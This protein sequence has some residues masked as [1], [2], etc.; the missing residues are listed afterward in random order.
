M[1]SV[2]FIFSIAFVLPNVSFFWYTKRTMF[3]LFTSKSDSARF[4]AFTLFNSETMEQ[5]TFE[6]L[7]K[8]D[9]RVYSCGPT[10]YDYAHIGNL[11]AYIFSDTLKRAL[12]YNGYNVNHT[13][14]YTDFGHLTSDADTG[15]DKMMKG[16]RRENMEVSLE[17]MRFLS[18]KYIEAFSTDI[19]SLNIL[20]PTQFARASDYVTEQIALIKTLEEKGY[21]YTTSDGVY[22]DISKFPSYGRL[23]NINVQE[24]KSGARVEKNSEKKNPAD[25]AVWKNG[26]L[27]WDSTWGK[28]FP[29]WHIECSAMAFATLGKQIDI[30]TGGVDNMPTHH[31]GEIAQCE[32]ATGKQFSKYWMHSEHI[33]INETKIG[34]SEGNGIILQ[35]LIDK[36][37]T[38]SDYRYWLLQSHYRT[39]V[40]FSYEALEASKQALTRLKRLMFEQYKDAKGKLD[41]KRQL[42]LV[43]A[44]NN[45]LD[46]PKVIAL[47]HEYIK[48]DSLTDGE[49][50]ALM[51]EADALLGLN[52][53]ID[54]DE[55]LRA[56]GH[57]APNSLPEDI[58]DLIDQREA[59]RIARNW[60]E[61]DRLRDAI[62]L[63]G[64]TLEDSSEGPKITKQ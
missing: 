12:L 20:P 3:K 37:F 56:L 2:Q 52:L 19:E 4:P 33:Q 50:K 25:F 14:N 60:A 21:T 18:D 13:I 10:V 15:D 26:E 57:I 51:L 35:D 53:S 62:G 16:L 36:G 7:S 27:G 55:G 5:E 54:S 31:N 39:K 32:S 8:N 64:Y 61:A 34:K 1:P 23:G 42:E 22:F 28:G 43:A 38:G 58:Q 40:N 24:L 17:S 44:V 48:D 29:G 9:V 41:E 49:K 47:L 45:D 63:K 59:A 46:T 6:P 11:R 30:H